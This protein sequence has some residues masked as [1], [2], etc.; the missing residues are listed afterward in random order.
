LTELQDDQSELAGV[1]G[2]IR[3][4]LAALAAR[5]EKKVEKL[6]KRFKEKSLPK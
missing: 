5:D 6:W 3:G 4:Y 1:A 2:Y